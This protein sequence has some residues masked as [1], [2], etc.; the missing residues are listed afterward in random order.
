MYKYIISGLLLLLFNKISLCQPSH[1]YPQI[2]KPCP[3]FILNEVH[4]YKIGKVD[5]R[6]FKGKPLIIDFFEKYC[7]VCFK[8]FPKINNL[9]QEFKDSL[10]FLLVGYDE[11]NIRQVYQKFQ[12]RYKINIPVAFDSILATRFKIIQYPYVIW[13]DASGIVQAITTSQEI[14]A[15]N[16]QNLIKGIPLNLTL[17][18]NLEQMKS[19]VY[20][21]P[22]KPL[23]ENGNGGNDS[24]YLYR[25][26]LMKWDLRQGF[27]FSS[28]LNASDLKNIQGVGQSIYSLYKEA[29]G[30]TVV[31]DE[32]LLFNDSGI[33]HYG[34]WYLLPVIETKN[35]SIFK[36][37]IYSGKNM[38]SYNLSVPSAT[39]LVDM[40][41]KMKSDLNNYFNLN[42]T[43]ETR[44]MPYWRL[45]ANNSA[46][47][48]LPTHHTNKLY[49]CDFSHLKFINQPVNN[50][51]SQLWIFNQDDIFIDETGIT[52][53]IDIQI[54]AV[55]TEFNDFKKALKAQGL[56][57]VQGT[58]QMK[59]L[60][61]RDPENKSE[62]KR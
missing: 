48:K 8:S 11:S 39:S 51:I 23:L 27:Y 40:Q 37:D 16:I 24:S 43:V 28:N 35:D 50:I 18:K 21:N 30:D 34:Q 15:D 29:Y 41:Q 5:L 59:V 9:Q 62:V 58:K 31:F 19:E 14:N 3:G 7:T 38:F 6:D 60:V 57:L 33:S 49:E 12:E 42:V 22:Y 52:G 55:L 17:V 13:I 61:F 47:T 4:Q 25:S 1:D 36:F 56:D 26:V 20:Y 46:R 45:V 53:N 44:T 32:P 2:G 10:Q 54:D